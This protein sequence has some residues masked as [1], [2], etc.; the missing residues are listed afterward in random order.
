MTNN[1]STSA[2]FDIVISTDALFY[3]FFDEPC[4]DDESIIEAKELS[5][6]YP[7]GLEL[8]EYELIPDDYRAVATIAIGLQAPPGNIV[9]GPAKKLIPRIELDP[10]DLFK[11]SHRLYF[12]QEA[13][14]EISIGDHSSLEWR[15]AKYQENKWVFGEVQEALIKVTERGLK[16]FQYGETA[17]KP[18]TL[19]YLKDFSKV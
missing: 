11:P 6:K 19:L 4:L 2:S 17:K 14:W 10:L 3:L 1:L 5:D 13:A 8:L 18:G 9:P 12:G 15:I 16:Y 7:E